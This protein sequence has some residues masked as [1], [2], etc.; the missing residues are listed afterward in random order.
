MATQKNFS[1]N[2]NKTIWI[3]V[4]VVV[5]VALVVVVYMAT[6]NGNSL[7]SAVN[8]PVG[9]KTD[10]G[11]VTP[12][13]VVAAPGASAVAS[14]G[15]VVAP[16]GQATQNNVQ[17][18]APTAPQQSNPIANV[19]EIPAK[20]IKLDVT[21][22]KGFTPNAFT[23]SAGAAVTI[24]ITGGDNLV[25]VFAFQDSS[26]SAVAVGVGPGETRAITFNA[27]TKAGDYKFYSNVPG[28]SGETGVMTVK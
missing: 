21:A 11:T 19:S 12:G 28:Q 5:V 14:S 4:G 6:K 17:P 2:K 7:Q 20:A 15:I 23:V 16:N 8:A 24:S 9:T 26:L 22:A 1:M 10:Y 13:G 25:H 27:P 3:I 18:S